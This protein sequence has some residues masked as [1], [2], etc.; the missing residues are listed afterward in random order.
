MEDILNSLR[1]RITVFF[2]SCHSSLRPDFEDKLNEISEWVREQKNT[3]KDK[4]RQT[5]IENLGK[6]IVAFVNTI[7]KFKSENSLEIKKGVLEVISSLAV[8]EGGPYGPALKVLCTISSAI[9]I[10]RKPKER[11][12]VG[13]LANVVHK[14]LVHFNKK[15]QDQKYNGLKRRVSDQTT[16]LQSMKPGE[17]LDDGT[18]WNDYVQ[19]LGE[20]SNRFESPLPFKYE[21][22]LTND[23]EVA[24]FVTAV[25][26]YCEAYCC[27]MALLTA[28][29]GKYSDL[30]SEYKEKEDAVNR[31]INCQRE[32][33]KEKLSFLSEEKYL[34][35]LGRL[36]CEGGKLTKIVALSRNLLGK[37]LV[38]AVRGSL[39]L[40]PMQSL[41]TV[42]SA[43]RKVAC[44]SVKGKV[45]GHQRIYSA[46]LLKWFLLSSLAPTFLVCVQFINETNFPMKIVSGRIGRRKAN[47]E[48]VQD[49]QPHTSYP[50]RACSY[51][52]FSPFRE[53]STGGYIILYLNGIISSDKEPPPEDARV[54]E[55]A[56]SEGFLPF[57][58]P[59]IDIKDKTVNEFTHGIDTYKK[60]TSRKTKTLYWFESGMHFM[61][62]GEILRD[63]VNNVAWRFVIQTFNPLAMED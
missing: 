63:S 46:N 32:D 24:D 44:Q 6:V 20:L 53:F 3:T 16:H 14:K 7:D 22:N 61:A 40:T 49:V 27:F 28:A 38:E 62:R 59:K 5:R 26:T 10:N 25:V 31:K 34:T 57:F 60:M 12:V 48:F 37:S 45:E 2:Q 52:S 56:L 4:S 50:R 54:L 30:G 13:Q 19:F 9:L 58:G 43:A 36:P 35:F 47:L 29:K 55:F 1:L 39:D 42:E 23:P 41:A 51:T 8:L 21:D 33:A 15:L 17:K 11:S 18:L